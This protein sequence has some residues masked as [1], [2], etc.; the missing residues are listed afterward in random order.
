MEG[1]LLT[2]FDPSRVQANAKVLQF[3]GLASGSSSSSS[4]PLTTSAAA[5]TFQSKGAH[6]EVRFLAL[7]LILIQSIN[8]I[9]F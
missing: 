4:S 6:G 5:A 7:V 8:A 1:L 9:A 2:G 3:F